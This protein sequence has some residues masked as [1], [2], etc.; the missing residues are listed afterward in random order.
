MTQ[1]EDRSEDD[2]ADDVKLEP[3]TTYPGKL[4][5][6]AYKDDCY[7]CWNC[8]DVLTDHVDILMD[9]SI[10]RFCKTRACINSAMAAKRAKAGDKNRLIFI[11]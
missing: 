1:A 10:V 3:S 8:F 2:L 7:V 6:V 9:Q 11:P 5:A 4:A